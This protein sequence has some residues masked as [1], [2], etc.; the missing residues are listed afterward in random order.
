MRSKLRTY[1]HNLTKCGH[2]RVTERPGHSVG[3]NFS[4]KSQI[5]LNKMSKIQKLLSEQIRL[6]KKE[7][8]QY[9]Y[10]L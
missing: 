10:I 3:N 7:Y 5:D 1:I 9:L 6:S 2:L 4:V 8:I